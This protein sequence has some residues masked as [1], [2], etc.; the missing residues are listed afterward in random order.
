[1]HVVFMDNGRSDI[2]ASDCKEILRCI[3]CSACQN[4]CPIYR[5]TSGH[6]YRATYGGP[7]G[8]V[9][10]P[11]LAGDDFRE[12]ADLPKACTLCSACN[13]VCPVDI[14][15]SDLLLRLRDRAKKE[16]IP[17][18]GTLPMGAFAHLASSPK[19]WRASMP[20]SKAMNVTPLNF[21]PLKP[22]QHW[23]GQRTLP[24]SKGG[25]FRKWMKNR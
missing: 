10:S 13:E 8:A 6:A 21:V 7:I 25:D 15:L 18:P 20:M 16:K 12:L 11:L 5:Q 19:I 17:S 24:K 1:M 23:L 9:L 4:V 22:I 2:L 3:R 14:P